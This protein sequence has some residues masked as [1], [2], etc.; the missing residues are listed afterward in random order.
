ML[1]EAYGKAATKKTQA[2]NWHKSFLDGHA[3]VMIIHAA[4]DRQL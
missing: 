2:Y 4:G 1:E 3:S